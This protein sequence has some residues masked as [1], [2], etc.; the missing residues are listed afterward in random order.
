MK[1]YVG[2]FV[3]QMEQNGNTFQNLADGFGTKGTLLQN[4]R[5][6]IFNI[7][8]RFR[9]EL[10]FYPNWILAVGLGF[11]QSRISVY[12]T[13]Y[14]QT[15]GALANRVSANR[16]FS[17]WAPEGALIWKPSEDRRHWIRASTG[18]GIPQFRQSLARSRYWDFLEP[19][20][21]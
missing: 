6:T 16:T 1:S 10:E 5:G 21:I 15:T 17:N 4:S 18:Y 8:G 12:A 3:N 9:E 11:E 20:S 2:F 19:T 13:N 7:G 14:N